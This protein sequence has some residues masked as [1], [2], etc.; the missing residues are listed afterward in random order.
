MLRYL[1]ADVEIETIVFPINALRHAPL[2]TIDGK[3]MKRAEIAEVEKR[4]EAISTYYE[5]S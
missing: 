1:T 5:M 2:S 4:I 3:P